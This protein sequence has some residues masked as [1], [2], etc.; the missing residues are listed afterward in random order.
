MQSGRTD[1][2]ILELPQLDAVFEQAVRLR[3]QGLRGQNETG[4]ARIRI[5]FSGFKRP[6]ADRSVSSRSAGLDGFTLN[7]SP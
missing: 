5:R 7:D 2:G 1:R 4:P 3:S 6:L